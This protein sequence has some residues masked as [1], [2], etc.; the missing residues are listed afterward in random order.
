MSD[1]EPAISIP[2]RIQSLRQIWQLSAFAQFMWTFSEAITS[3]DFDYDDFESAIVQDNIEYLL[4]LRLILLK[5]VSSNRHL[6]LENA[7]EYTRRQFLAKKP[8]ENPFSDDIQP[9]SFS[10]LSDFHKARPS[11]L[12]TD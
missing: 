10:S 9:K 8:S 12:C 6:S 4:D 1:S 7:D 5:R 3:E 11:M 2:N